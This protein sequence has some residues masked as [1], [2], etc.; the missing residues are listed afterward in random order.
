MADDA[1]DEIS[2]FRLDNIAEKAK[3]KTTGSPSILLAGL[4]LYCGQTRRE[5]LR[6][7]NAKPRTTHSWWVPC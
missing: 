7:N 2:L 1:G 3:Q 5:G 6:M 4:V